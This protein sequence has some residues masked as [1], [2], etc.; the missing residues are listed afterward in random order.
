[1]LIATAATVFAYWPGLSGPFLFDDSVAIQN[2]E[3]LK[4]TD[5]DLKS[6]KLAAFSHETGVLY[7]PV[8]MSSF[9]L[10]Y[11]F[12]GSDS[13]SFKVVNLIIHLLNGWLI[14]F[15]VRTLAGLREG[16]DSVGNQLLAAA[17]ALVWLV[18]PINLTSVLYVVQRM[19][20]L[21]TLF[22]LLALL[23]YVL[24]RMAWRASRHG[25]ASAW[26]AG[27]G[28]SFVLA[29]F[30]KE[31]AMLLPFYI[32]LVEWLFLEGLSTHRHGRAHVYGVVLS[33]LLIPLALGLAFYIY[34][35]MWGGFYV[36]D[37]SLMERLL[38][39]FRVLFYYMG[40]IVFPRPGEYSLFHD[41][42]P[43]STG[44]FAP[45]TTAV[46]MVGIGGL[47][48]LALRFRKSHTLASFGILLFL[49]SHLMESTIIPLELI[50]EHRNYLGSFGIVLAV[51]VGIKSLARPW[52]TPSLRGMLIAVLG[53]F[54]VA[55]THARAL[56]WQDINRLSFSMLNKHP[57]SARVNYQAAM[58]YLKLSADPM[59]DVRQRDEFRQLA[60]E[61]FYHAAQL[62]PHDAGSLLAIMMI[63]ALNRKA[64]HK[65][66]MDELLGKQ[67]PKIIPLDVPQ[68][69]SEMA[70]RRLKDELPSEL[71][72]DNL[73]RISVC[74]RQAD[75]KFHDGEVDALFNAFLDNPGLPGNSN[76][77]ANLLGELALRAYARKDLAKAQAMIKKAIQINPTM[78]MFKLN[79][80]VI[81]ATSGDQDQAMAYL[82]QILSKPQPDAIRIRAEEMLQSLRRGA[83]LVAPPD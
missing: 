72:T 19:T 66:K 73:L 4:I 12:W 26:F 10:N 54:L 43:L 24:G 80:A 60:V 23:A 3:Y 6:L 34:M 56:S 59:S 82:K 20:S 36:R 55:I 16:S 83:S 21:S 15:L 49:V 27:A 13:F 32:F 1:M 64:I 62:N 74:E 44:V 37:F 71:A 39:E 51:L 63:D 18:H 67:A 48:Y 76:R 70:A 8:A 57:E 58:V 28:L 52:L 41:D 2:N 79:G 35:E 22:V 25:K 14:F 65:A 45:W 75:C 68:G 7:R 69:I 53:V 50:H 33:W 40:L 30:S 29:L 47:V 9:A 77:M 31:N 17:V 61:R 38:T 11:Y 81:M 42:F 78:A 5:L 46:S